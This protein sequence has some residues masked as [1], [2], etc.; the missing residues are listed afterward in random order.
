V[1][2][3]NTGV[4]AESFIHI[5]NN[6]AVGSYHTLDQNTFILFPLFLNDRSDIQHLEAS[7]YEEYN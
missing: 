3:A 5:E 1:V 7:K 2:H 4:R 6:Y